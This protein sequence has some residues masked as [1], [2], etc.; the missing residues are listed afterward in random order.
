MRK[1]G[2]EQKRAEKEWMLIS[3]RRAEK[4]V[5]DFVKG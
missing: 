4:H 3:Y 5:A 2:E 1:P